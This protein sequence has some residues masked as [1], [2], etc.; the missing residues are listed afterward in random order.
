VKIRLQ[1]GEQNY[2][3]FGIEQ[4][5]DWS[6]VITWDRVRTRDTIHRYSS[7]SPEVSAHRTPEDA[8]RL[9]YHTSGQVNYHGWVAV[10]PLFYDPLAMISEPRLVITV[11]IPE[12]ARLDKLDKKPS[13][14]DVILQIAKE[15]GIARFTLGVAFFPRN[16]ESP[17]NALLRL[18]YDIFS[19]VLI[20]LPDPPVPAGLDQ[21]FHHIAPD[22]PHNGRQLTK[23]LAM[24][25]YHQERVNQREIFIYPPNGEGVYSLFAS[26]EMRVVPRVKIRF[27]DPEL[28]I[29]VL[30]DRARPMMIPFR[31]FRGHQR[32][33]KADLRGEIESIEL[34]AEL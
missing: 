8:M 4:S 12:A 15:I 3:L 32:V 1:H 19:V 33:V 28:R 17:P 30:Q 26:V 22:G 11:S 34:D 7:R 21:H 13:D 18:D 14:S 5:G 9:I 20:R 23:N 24:L 31:I 6:I 29:E 2:R 25:A 16:H 10:E 27:A